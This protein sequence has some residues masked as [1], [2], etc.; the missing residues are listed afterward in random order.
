MR[1]TRAQLIFVGHT[2]E[3]CW[4]LNVL[5]FTVIVKLLVM[6]HLPNANSMLRN[7]HMFISNHLNKLMGQCRTPIS[8]L[9]NLTSTN[10]INEIPRIP[11]HG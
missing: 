8:Q 10:L 5:H 9:C 2:K 7:L 11:H 4:K 1:A 3:C 6:E